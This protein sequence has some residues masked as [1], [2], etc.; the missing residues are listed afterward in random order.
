MYGIMKISLHQS[1]TIEEGQWNINQNVIKTIKMQI[2]IYEFANLIT[3][4][5]AEWSSV[6]YILKTVIIIIVA[7]K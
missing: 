7:E 3:C 5:K 6:W 2:L 1:Y 4:S